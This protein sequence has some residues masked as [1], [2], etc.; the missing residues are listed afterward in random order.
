MIVPE[1]KMLPLKVK[2]KA[3]EINHT[4]SFFQA[5]LQMEKID[6]NPSKIP[7][8]LDVNKT[9]YPDFVAKDP[10]VSLNPERRIA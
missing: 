7:S 3:S 9:M 1:E 5:E 4:F 8:W 2:C 10:F 6:K